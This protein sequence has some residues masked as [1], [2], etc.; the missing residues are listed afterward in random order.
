MPSI[1]K[2]LQDFVEFAAR[3]LNSGET[4][5]ASVEELVARW[6][7]DAESAEAVADVRQGLADEVAGKAQP[8]VEAFADIRRQLGI[9]A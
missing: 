9:T 1:Q 2:D 5:P 3:R 7:Q 8:A 6:R 4:A